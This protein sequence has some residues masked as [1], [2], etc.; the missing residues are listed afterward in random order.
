MVSVV[1]SKLLASVRS[2]FALVRVTVL[3]EAT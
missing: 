3:V 2:R 1:G